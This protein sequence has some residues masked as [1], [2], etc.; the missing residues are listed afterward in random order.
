MQR[1]QVFLALILAASSLYARGEEPFYPRRIGTTFDSP[2]QHWEFCF[3]DTPVDALQTTSLSSVNLRLSWKPDS[4]RLDK[5]QLVAELTIPQ[6]K[7]SAQKLI[8]KDEFK[9][10]IGK[11]QDLAAVCG[12]EVVT[13]QILGN[14]VSA[15]WMVEGLS[16][17]DVTVG[18]IGNVI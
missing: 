3:A 15:T 6:K 12:S 1:S 7:I 18:R 17:E 4:I 13:G 2:T 10:K 8:L 9:T 14:R 11:K 16:L 5:V